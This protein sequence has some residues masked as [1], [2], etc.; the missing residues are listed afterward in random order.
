MQENRRK[1]S[2]SLETEVDYSAR[3]A[4]LC[5]TNMMKPAPID[6]LLDLLPIYRCW[7]AHFDVEEN[8]LV[9]ALMKFGALTRCT[10]ASL[11]DSREAAALKC[12]VS[13]WMQEQCF[14]AEWLGDY[15][16]STLMVHAQDR[17]APRSWYY[18]E[19][20]EALRPKPIVFSP[21]GDES[22]PQFH[23]RIEGELCKL[24][25]EDLALD[26]FRRGVRKGQSQ[27]AKW[28]VARFMGLTFA[29][30]ARREYLDR[31]TVEK[32]VR[33]FMRRA[34]LKPSA[35]RLEAPASGI[36]LP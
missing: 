32:A 11:D 3:Y 7:I 16:L 34:Q 15:A 10:M 2:A 12:S 5:A 8:A 35:T 24:K 30:I 1:R 29:Q 4:F 14:R 13:D 27:P 23:R 31:K 9:A 36:P 20:L 21:R 28:T 33:G 17:A 26:R 18:C 6:S 19:P 25:K 22:V